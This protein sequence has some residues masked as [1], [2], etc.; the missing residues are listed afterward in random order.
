MSASFI[1]RLLICVVCVVGANSCANE[2]APINRVQANA[3]EKSFFVGDDLADPKDNP[4][5]YYRPTIVNVDYGTTQDEL[6]TASGAQTIARV[7]FEITEDLLVARLTYERIADTGGDTP[8]SPDQNSGQIVAAFKIQSHFDVKRS[9][10]PT[11]GEE[12]NVIDENSTDSP[13]YAREFMRVD[14][15]QNLITSAYQLDTLAAVTA[16]DTAFQYEPVAYSATNPKD[17][18]APVFDEKENYFDITNK[19]FVTPQKVFTPFGYLPAC[20]LTPDFFGGTGPTGNCN[21]SE[22]KVRLSF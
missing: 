17:P 7:S 9:Y 12:L 20:Y 10:N 13:W 11:T 19:L 22:I 5:F 3:L 15:S 6:F 16:F 21:P 2:R 18:D 8:N 4:E 1:R 14:W